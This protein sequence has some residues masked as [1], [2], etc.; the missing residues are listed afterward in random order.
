MYSQVLQK[1]K[2]QVCFFLKNLSSLLVNLK[3]RY[4]FE[5]FLFCWSIS[6]IKLVSQRIPKDACKTFYILFSINLYG[7]QF[8]YQV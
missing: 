4:G 6:L 2:P 8:K 3:Q 1:S 7:G 5:H